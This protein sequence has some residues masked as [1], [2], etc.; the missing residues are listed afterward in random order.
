MR[1]ARPCG[2]TWT[3]LTTPTFIP[4]TCLDCRWRPASTI[5]RI[6]LRT[7]LQGG[8]QLP[9]REYYLSDSEHMKEVR[10]KYQAHISAMLKLAGF[11]DTD[12]RAERIVP[13]GARHR[14]KASL[15]RRER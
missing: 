10:T 15:A 13:S 3:R 6:T 7:F 12:A 11:S 9:D 5:Q 1:W 14:R 2:P 8:L 4:R